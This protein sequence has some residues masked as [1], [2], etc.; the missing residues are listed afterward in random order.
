MDKRLGLMPGSAILALL[1]LTASLY[2]QTPTAT[3]LGSVEDA[4]GARI[5]SATV[6]IRNAGAGEAREVASDGH[7]EFTAAQLPP[8]QYDISIEKTGFRGLRQTGVE[9]QVDQLARLRFQ[10]E[11][12]ST[13]ESIE[14]QAEA[15]AINT[16]NATKG[17]V[18]TALEMTQMPLNGRDFADLAFLVPGVVPVAQGGGGYLFNV[19]GARAGDTN[20]IVDGF[21]N[22]SPRAGDAQVHPNLDSLQEFKMQTSGYSA[23]YGRQAGGVINMVLRSG[24]NQLHGTVFEFVRND[25]FDARNFF[26]AKKHELRRNQ[27]GSTVSGPLV[28]PGLYQGRDHTFFLVSWESQ[29]QVLGQNGISRVPEALE[30]A[31]DFSQTRASAGGQLVTLKDPLGGMFPGNRIPAS[32]MS[33]VALK[34]LPYYPLPNRPGQANNYLVN[35]PNPAPWDSFVFKLTFFPPHA[36]PDRNKQSQS[37]TWAIQTATVERLQKEGILEKPAR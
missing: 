27:F 21:N 7:G 23:E 16:E 29:R 1:L 20:M 28:I 18:I 15:P 37:E 4:S 11:A 36:F 22:Q 26:D 6:K 3:V 17:E 24:T 8:G 30:R 33:P 2:S 13:S 31:G 9:L 10:L 12:G 35:L 14:I 32:R 5:A 19:N 25:L 34:L